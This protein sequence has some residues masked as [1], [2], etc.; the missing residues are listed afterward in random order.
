MS[1]VLVGLAIWLAS[2]V[3]AL[4]LSR[5]ARLSSLV[6]AC[7]TVLG[8]GVVA[9]PVIRVLGGGSPVVFRHPWSVPMGEFVVR[10]DALSAWFLVPLLVLAVLAAVYGVSYW[11]SA[12]RTRSLGP[13]W[14]FFCTL[15]ASLVLVLIAANAVLFLAAWETM[16]LTS[17]FL[18]TFDDEQESVR[19]AGWVYLVATHLGTA[20]LLVFFLLAARES[21]SMDFVVWA[22]RGLPIAPGLLFVLAVV[23][24][25]AKAGFMPFHVWLPEAHPAAPSHVSA[26]MSGILIKTGIY[27]LI[28]ALTFLGAP[29]LWWAWLLLG[30]GLLSG[31]LGILFALAQRD[32]KRLLAYSSVENIGIIAVGLGLGVLGLNA[33]LPVL[34][35]LGFG[36]ALLHVWNHALFKGLLFLAA[37]SVLH[38][39][40]TRNIEELGGLLRRMRWT[41]TTFVVGAAA[42]SALPP[43]NGFIGELL[44]YLGAFH[45]ATVTAAGV[46]VP[47]WLVIGGLALIGGLVVAALAKAFGIVFLGEPRSARAEHAHEADWGMR[48]PLVVLAGACVAVGLG[49]PMVLRWAV[50]P[51]GII[52][53][54]GAPLAAQEL[55]AATRWV[56]PVFIAAIILLGLVLVLTLLRRRLLARRSVTAA[57]TWDC[58]YARPAVRMQYTGG[59]FA[60][61]LT[62]LFE[63]VLRSRNR[64][65]RPEGVFPKEASLATEVPDV[66]EQGIYGPVFRGVLQGLTWFRWLQQGKVQW[67]VLY[68][69]VTLLALLIWKLR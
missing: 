24:F 56:M 45:A 30:V 2:G 9:G 44:L 41:G 31:V 22:E 3:M 68:I 6:A 23:G 53:R 69:A 47:G 64:L 20:F 35:V 19:R 60:Q 65:G 40:G 34:S 49:A 66:C 51:L 12:A 15:V 26:L 16:A 48:L 57:G 67:Y 18:V 62:A 29:A 37:G 5:R 25:G 33:G 10:L 50:A 55:G 17:F 8:A 42:I 38:A 59:S 1:V 28:R 63:R 14:F 32:L 11:A 58:G 13:A 7:G 43:L 21:G 39:T 52:T 4:V 54:L 36:G 27:G 61:P 46:A